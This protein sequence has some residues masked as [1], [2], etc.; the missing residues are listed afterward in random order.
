MSANNDLTQALKRVLKSAGLTYADAAEHLGLSEASVKRLFK[1]RSFSVERMEQLCEMAGADLMQLVRSVDDQRTQMLELSEEQETELA[2]DLPLFVA[3]IC[4]LNR[5]RFEDVL[6]DYQI[7][8]HDLQQLF[9]RLDR[10]GIIE[11][12][13]NNRYRLRV[14]RGFQWRAN[15]PIERH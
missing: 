5:Y 12:L 9:A 3:A 13:P 10:I 1:E 8:R 2:Q 4:V 14:S 7:D 15:G 11:L 6:A